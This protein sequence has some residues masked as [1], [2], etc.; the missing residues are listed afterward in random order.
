MATGLK[1]DADDT[2][3]KLFTKHGLVPNWLMPMTL[4]QRDYMT[5]D[6]TGFV[7]QAGDIWYARFE[8]QLPGQERPFHSLKQAARY[9]KSRTR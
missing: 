4:T 1:P 5:P 6:Q 3:R 7:W 8:S 9:A 2:K